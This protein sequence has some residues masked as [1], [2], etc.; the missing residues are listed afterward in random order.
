MSES[1]E[2]LTARLKSLKAYRL[3]LSE[4]IKELD[5]KVRKLRYRANKSSRSSKSENP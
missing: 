2:E 4:E 1:L 3:K 5:R